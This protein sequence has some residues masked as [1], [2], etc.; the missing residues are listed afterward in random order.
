IYRPLQTK[1]MRDAERSGLRAI[2]GLGMLVYQGAAAFELWTGK[3]APIELM[4]RVCLEHL[5]QS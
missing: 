1:L 4:R 2:G 5:N 3:K